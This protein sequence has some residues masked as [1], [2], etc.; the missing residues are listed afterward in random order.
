[1][2]RLPV[3]RGTTSSR[4]LPR[5][6]EACVRALP[7]NFL[8]I[9]DFY[10]ERS[11]HSADRWGS[12][13]VFSSVVWLYYFCNSHIIHLVVFLLLRWLWS[14]LLQEYLFLHRVGFFS[15]AVT[16]VMALLELVF[17][18]PWPDRLCVRG[19]FTHHD[20]KF[21][22]N[23]VPLKR[24]NLSRQLRFHF[25]HIS[26]ILKSANLSRFEV[27]LEWLDQSACIIV[28]SNLWQSSREVRKKPDYLI[29][30]EK[31]RFNINSLM[32]LLT[33]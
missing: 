31:V 1:M 8:I 23:Q 7:A 16:A 15:S 6:R 24:K 13:A 29:N 19:R 21:L 5:S 11:K 14:W 10:W 17:E 18:P 30:R 26:S 25:S 20:A 3:S 28:T 9:I 12:S 22:L 33:S 4:A 27:V 32:G 2:M